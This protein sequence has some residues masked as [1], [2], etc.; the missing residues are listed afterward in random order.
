MRAQEGSLKCVAKEGTPLLKYKSN[1]DN[2]FPH[3]CCLPLHFSLMY[4]NSA[5]CFKSRHGSCFTS[6]S[7]SALNECLSHLPLSFHLILVL[8]KFQLKYPFLWKSFT[9]DTSGGFKEVC[10]FFGTPP[11][12]RRLLS[13]LPSNLS[14]L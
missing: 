4:Y 5:R 3:G 7:I 11:I 12:V 1:S 13:S 8:F 2:P 9:M 10:K 14:A 6:V